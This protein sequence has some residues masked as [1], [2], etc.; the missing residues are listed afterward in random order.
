MTSRFLAIVLTV[1][2]LLGGPFPMSAHPGHDHKIMG[3]IAS[4]DGEHVLLETSNGH[5]MSFRLVKTT[6]LV[7]GKQV[8]ARGDLKAGVRV[9]VNVGDGEEPLQAKE[10]QYSIAPATKV[11]R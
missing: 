4:I 6:K 7:R 5:E 1:G 3:T 9:V 10:I 8:G 2:V 11:A